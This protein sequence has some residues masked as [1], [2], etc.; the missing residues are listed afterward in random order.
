M[1]SLAFF[2]I[3][4]LLFNETSFAVADIQM[5]EG[6]RGEKIL[7]IGDMHFPLPL[8]DAEN[9]DLKH[10]EH[11]LAVLERQSQRELGTVSKCVYES[12]DDDSI[13][14]KQFQCTF[15]E[16]RKKKEWHLNSSGKITLLKPCDIRNFHVAKVI[17][18]FFETYK[19]LENFAQN[20]NAT[21]HDIR[22]E[23]NNL[24][25]I[26]IIKDHLLSSQKA[27]ANSQINILDPQWFLN[28]LFDSLNRLKTEIS[29]HQKPLP[30][31]EYL[32]TWSEKL[33]GRFS[34]LRNDIN[35]IIYENKT[36]DTVDIL[37]ALTLRDGH[38]KTAARF[39]NEL[40]WAAADI[41]F[42]FIVEQDMSKPQIL[43]LGSAHTQFVG[44]YLIKN[45]GFTGRKSSLVVTEEGIKSNSNERM[46]FVAALTEGLEWIHEQPQATTIEPAT[47]CC[48]LCGAENSLH[49]PLKRCAGCKTI[50]YCSKVCQVADWQHHKSI[51]HK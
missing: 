36:V 33:I 14:E 45:L 6:R 39:N 3:A 20:Q 23:E 26:G 30:S 49:K 15:R 16:L 18:D 28:S 46:G 34:I 47:P 5:L 38:E 10:M 35:N 2:I 12:T 4:V 27:L 22:D 8:E 42:L 11:I 44:N 43:I 40:T 9:I 48:Q 51:C 13:D 7:L 21:I 25:A 37:F 19:K 24:D 29:Q 17:Q 32:R 1:K 41:Y 31:L 50:R